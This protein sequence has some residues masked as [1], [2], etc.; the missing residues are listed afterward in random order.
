MMK[1]VFCLFFMS[2]VLLCAP[3]PVYAH[4]YVQL[5][6]EG[7]VALELKYDGEPVIGGVFACVKVADIACDN[8]DYYYVM[9]LDGQEYRGTLPDADTVYESVAENEGFFVN[10]TMVQTNEAG[11]VKFQALK[12]GL[13]LLTQTT[14]APG[15]Y[16]MKPFF[17]SVPYLQ[18]G[19]YV[20]DVN[21][22]VKS[23]LE[24]SMEETPDEP[25]PD[26]RLPQT[27]QLKWPVP[28]LAGSGMILFAVG[29]GLRFGSKRDDYEG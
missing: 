16:K 27:G 28:V 11:S 1:R 9:L 22:N 8:G 23:E 12:P 24:Q 10:H 2:V 13:Y 20:Y 5:D 14:A 4:D 6:K 3:L 15:Y 29:L 26:D 18:D 19:R 7:C 21:A 25:E 17:V